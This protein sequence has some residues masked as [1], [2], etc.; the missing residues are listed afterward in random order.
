MAILLWQFF[1]VLTDLSFS[2][3]LVKGYGQ[4]EAFEATRLSQ[5]GIFPPLLVFSH[6]DDLLNECDEFVTLT[7]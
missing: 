3:Y 4:L 6:S 7:I 2:S 1:E 5:D